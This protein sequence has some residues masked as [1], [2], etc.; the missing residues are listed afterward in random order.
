LKASW[1]KI[2]GIA[3]ALLL[4]GGGCRFAT[5]LPGVLAGSEPLRLAGVAATQ[6]AATPKA[7][8]TAGAEATEP[9]NEA[10]AAPTSQASLVLAAVTTEE[11]SN[12]PRYT[13]KARYPALEWGNDPRVKAF[14]EA[15]EDIALGEIRAFKEGV[16]RIPDDST[17]NELGS[18][19]EID[20]SP[21]TSEKGI[22]SIRYQMMFYMAGAAHPGLY[23]YA[24]NYDLE[25]GETIAL[26]DLFQEDAPF[27][28]TLSNACLEDLQKRGRLEW[29]DGALPL[30]E[31]YRVWN[32][33]PD[34]LL[35][36]FDEYQV[37]PY[38]A[39]AQEVMVPYDLLRPLL[40]EEGPLNRYLGD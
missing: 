17:F 12:Q 22:L 38:A 34:G 32:I 8:P 21:T 18:S 31:N 33:T 4:A 3:A 39:G 5:R 20:F 11:S 24:L 1:R 14:N 28:D 10:T 29:E 13:I 23:S 16:Y 26:E 7:S 36:T 27:L 37:A 25:Q 35:I 40:R 9:A 19:L 2:A 6:P 15:A 30:A